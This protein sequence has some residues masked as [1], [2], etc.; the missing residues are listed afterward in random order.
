MSATS[1]GLQQPA[2]IWP[3]G[4]IS[5]LHPFPSHSFIRNFSVPRKATLG[6]GAAA[7]PSAVVPWAPEPPRGAPPTGPCLSASAAVAGCEAAH[8]CPAEPCGTGPD[9]GRAPTG[10]DGKI[11]ALADA[12]ALGDGSH[13]GHL[14]PALVTAGPGGW[15]WVYSIRARTTEMPKE[16]VTSESWSNLRGT[17][18]GNPA[19]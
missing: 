4:D 8:P 1:P 19:W 9:V 3:W 15:P 11:W 17:S 10:R 2:S 14:C 16:F 18:D 6:S 5:S 7:S 13:S 12:P